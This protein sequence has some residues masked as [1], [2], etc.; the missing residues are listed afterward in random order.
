MNELKQ[1]EQRLGEAREALEQAHDD[2]DYQVIAEAE[3]AR[4][5]A[6]NA[7]E[8]IHWEQRVVQKAGL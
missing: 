6:V 1:A 7:V 4:D 2:G 5:V 8:R 3:N